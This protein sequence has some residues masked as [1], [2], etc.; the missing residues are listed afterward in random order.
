MD[1]ALYSSLGHTMRA[2]CLRVQARQGSSAPLLVEWQSWV[3]AFVA[4]LYHRKSAVRAARLARSEAVI[5][6]LDDP[7]AGQ[8]GHAAADLAWAAVHLAAGEHEKAE[9]FGRAARERL[10][11]QLGTAAWPTRSTDTQRHAPNRRSATDTADERNVD[12]AILAILLSG[13]THS[14]R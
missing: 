3:K 7:V 13:P 8:F 4:G 12:P 2:L 1:H 11:S 14:R 9:A 10:A 6:E 5:L